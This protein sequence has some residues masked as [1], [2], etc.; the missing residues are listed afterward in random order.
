MATL[1]HFLRSLV[2]TLLA[3]F[4]LS[5][6]ALSTLM[7]GLLVL[8]ASPVASIAQPCYVQASWFLAVFGGGDRLEGM[9]VIAVTIGV[10]T[11][12]LGGFSAYKRSQRSEWHLAMSNVTKD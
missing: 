2:V 3:G 11:A 6:F 7:G 9:V 10:V 5:I 8:Q 4:L 1:L 12:L